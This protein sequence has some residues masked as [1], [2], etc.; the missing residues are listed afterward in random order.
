[1]S[2]ALDA[3]R[4]AARNWY[5][6]NREDVARLRHM[7]I[8]KQKKAEYDKVHWIAYYKKHKKKLLAQR[9]EWRAKFPDYD[10]NDALKRNHGITLAQYRELVKFQDGCCAICGTQNFG[11]VGRKLHVDHDHETGEL[12]GLLCQ[13]CNLGIANFKDDIKLL[14]NAIEYL[15]ACR[16]V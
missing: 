3:K 16:E 8:S 11:G 2:V 10:V 9:K 15:K 7:T 5:Y 6:R 14:K 4:R 12:R 13:H 1:M